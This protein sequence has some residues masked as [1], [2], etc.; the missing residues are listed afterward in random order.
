MFLLCLMWFVIMDKCRYIE[1]FAGVGGFHVGLDRA[2][3]EFYQCVMANQWEQSSKDQF[4]A[5]I[6]KKRFPDVL[7][8]NDDINKVSGKDYEAELLMGGFCCLSGDTMVLTSNGYK[9][10][11]DVNVGDMVLGHDNQYH[12][13]IKFMDQGVRKTYHIEATGFDYIEVTGNH[14]FFVR[15]KKSI[16]PKI[17]GKTT[18]IRQFLEPEWKCIDEIKDSYNEYYMGTSINQ[19]SIIPEWK[20]ITINKN[21]FVTE[22]KC[23]LNMSDE[24]LWYIIGRFIGDG[25]I[26]KQQKKGDFRYVYKGIGI[27]CGKYELEELTSKISDKYKYTIAENRTSYNLIF[28]NVELASFCENFYSSSEHTAKNK[29]LPGFVFDLPVNLLEQLL[30]GYEDSDGC[31]TGIYHQ[32][33]S[34]SKELLYGIAHCIEKVYHKPT[35]IYKNNVPN[36]KVIEGRLVNQKPFYTLRYRVDDNKHKTYFYENGYVWFPIS[37]IEE[38]ENQQ[39][40]DIEVEGSHSFV[41]NQCVVHNCQDYSVVRNLSQSLGIEGKKGVLWWQVTRLISEMK[42]KP[43]FL[44]FENVDRMLI[45]PSKQKG[46]DYALIL[47]SLVDLGYDVEWRIIN[48]AEYGMPQKRKR[49]FIF[50]FLKGEFDV[51][52]PDEW[53]YSDG[54]LAKSFPVKK[55][56]DVGLWG[57]DGRRLDPDLANL[58][59]Y[60]NKGNMSLHPFENAGVV[61]DGLVYTTKVEP[62]YSGPY[63]TLG[64]ILVTGDDRKYITP[65]YYVSDKDAKKWEY[66]KGHK[67]FERTSKDGYKYMYTEGSMAFPDHLDKPART[68]ITSEVTKKPNRF[69]HI[70]K[71]P[72]NG[73]LRRLVPLELERVQMFPDNH[74][75][76]TTDRKRGFLMGNALVCG[77]VERIGK[78]LRRRL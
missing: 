56:V 50:G 46:R 60:F 1:L 66:V 16:T 14:N 19:N 13:V 63:T 76:G 47:Q 51:T 43:K 71:D 17:N 53:L 37:K 58:S 59:K 25:W 64:D 10:I 41:A 36:T 11:T 31:I 15:K 20:G 3:K 45:S 70:I 6:Y 54:V 35:L 39:V 33:T 52:S 34:I 29:R 73:K 30:M 26:I 62:D 5:N 74:T 55:P 38:S 72:V 21:Q 2:D 18:R 40:Y 4:A 48:A 78:E 27:C 69:T 61:I 67:E 7:L 75:E 9:K 23:D 42:E 44:L 8:I 24:N 57:L 28:S 68:L 49:V 77:I 65:E 12:Q 22:T 32:F